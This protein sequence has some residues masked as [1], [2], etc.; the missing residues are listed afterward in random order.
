MLNLAARDEVVD[1]GVHVLRRRTVGRHV[2]G[3]QP[4]HLLLDGREQHLDVVVH[5]GRRVVHGVLGA[6]DVRLRDDVRQIV[7]IQEGTEGRL[8]PLVEV[9][10]QG[11]AAAS[12]LQLQEIS[13]MD[14][15]G[16]TAEGA[17]Q[18]VVVLLGHLPTIGPAK[19]GTVKEHVVEMRRDHAHFL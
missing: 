9:G 3:R 1:V 17:C 14:T 13:Q 7:G 15:D 2:D 8:L 12:W 18:L 19:E 16:H 5:D 11:K 4:R 6:D 10:D